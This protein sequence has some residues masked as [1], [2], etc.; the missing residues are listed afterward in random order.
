MDVKGIVKGNINRVKNAMGILDEN[1]KAE[2]ARRM[3]ICRR[4]LH[5]DNTPM[6]IWDELYYDLNDYR[7]GYTEIHINPDIMDL[8]MKLSF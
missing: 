4:C 6:L 8:S 5:T 3:G 2:G 7:I 1:T